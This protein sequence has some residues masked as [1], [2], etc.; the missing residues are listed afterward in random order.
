M[1]NSKTAASQAR[2][3][4]NRTAGRPAG[5]QPVQ[6]VTQAIARAQQGKVRVTPEK[7]IEMAGR[8]FGERKFDQAERACRQI[9]AAR[10]ENADAHN[11]LGV[12]L[13][14]LGKPEEAVS[15]LRRA[16]ELAPAAASI[17]ANRGEVLR[18]LKRP[19]E[20][21]LTAAAPRRD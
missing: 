6:D 8:L 1:S 21:A 18:Q 4:S 3:K 13:N 14:A 10:P 2:N 17:Y 19:D 11:I 9:I 12:T 16:I 5:A 7:A 20:A 15:T